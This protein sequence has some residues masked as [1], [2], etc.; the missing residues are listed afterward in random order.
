[1]KKAV[2]YMGIAAVMIAGLFLSLYFNNAI[3]TPKSKIEKDARISHKIDPSWQV[4]K[5][6]TDTLSAMLFYDENLS[7]YTFSIY[8]N[9]EGLSFGYFF[10]SGGSANVENE[11]IAEYK[12][13]GRQEKVYL[14][15]NKQ[16]VI[17]IEIANG[18]TVEI[19][20]IDHTKPFAVVLPVGLG[21]IKICDIDGNVL[22]TILQTL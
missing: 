22:P 13:Q 21:A 4:A 19:I 12:A 20:D 9:R 14:S 17:K 10:R 18:N 16:Q 6:T 5:S 15:M 7:R 8:E 2:K 11:G 1:M 3:G